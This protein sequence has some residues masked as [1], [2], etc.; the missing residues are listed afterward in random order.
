MRGNKYEK[1]QR[2]PAKK[3]STEKKERRNI[4]SCQ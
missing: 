2:L 4:L 3:I 1:I